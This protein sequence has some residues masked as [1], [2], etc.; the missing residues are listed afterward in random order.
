MNANSTLPD[1]AEIERRVMEYRESALRH[2]VPAQ[3]VYQGA[4]CFCPWECGE[5]IDAIAFQF[6]QWAP[7]AEAEA[8]TV[9]WWQ[10]GGLVGACPRCGRLV[11]Y[12]LQDK[13]R[14][15][16]LEHDELC[17]PPAWFEKAHLIRKLAPGSNGT[18]TCV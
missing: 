1:A 11:R 18:A 10:K 16:K 9:A 12:G 8:W 15:E 13:R 4:A 14:V 5:R 6:D 17:L 7:I 3:V 2:H